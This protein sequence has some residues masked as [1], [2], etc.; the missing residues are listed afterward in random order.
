MTQ[1]T[2]NKPKANLGGIPKE[3]Q[4]FYLPV[5][6]KAVVFVHGFSDSLCRINGFAKMLSD[7]GITTKG[8]LLPGHGKTVAELAKTTPNDWYAEVEREVLETAKRHKEVYIIGISFGGNL[9]LK[10]DAEHPNIAK[11]IVTLESP[12]R[13]KNQYLTRAAIPFAKSFGMKYWKKKFLKKV[14]HPEKETVFKQGVLDSM[15][16]DNIAQIIDFLENKQGFLKKVTTDVLIVQS[17]KSSLLTKNSAQLIYSSISSKR[18]EIY[19]IENVYH[20]FL[21]ETAK[22]SILIKSLRFFNIEI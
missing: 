6:E 11:G 18:K 21:N 14:K 4:P 15:P 7:R 22:K 9:A 13:I 19:R 5:G 10:F 17:E 16:L 8:V 3:A 2:L 20:A 1:A 12:M